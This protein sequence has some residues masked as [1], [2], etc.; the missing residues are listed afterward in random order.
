[1]KDC[2]WRFK[3]DSF[4][5]IYT[6]RF[7]GDCLF[8]VLDMLPKYNLKPSFEYFYH[9]LRASLFVRQSL[10]HIL[11]DSVYYPLGLSLTTRLRVFAT[12][13]QHR[14]SFAWVQKKQLANTSTHMRSLISRIELSL[15]FFPH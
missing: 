11:R 2:G 5:I 9:I 15:S 1:M 14:Q 4:G 3:Q 7:H 6:V 8:L 10:F 12:R 13:E